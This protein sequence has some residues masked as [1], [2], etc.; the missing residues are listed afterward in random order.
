M[1]KHL[2]HFV[3]NFVKGM[4]LGNTMID[5]AEMRDYRRSA[6]EV[7]RQKNE[8][9]AGIHRDK[10]GIERGKAD[11]YIER[12]KALAAKDRAK[13]A[14]GSG[15]AN[16]SGPVQEWTQTWGQGV[17]QDQPNYGP[18]YVQ[19][20]STEGTTAPTGGYSSTDTEVGTD[21]TV[22]AARGGR[23][24]QRMARGGRSRQLAG[25]I[26]QGAARGIQQMN[27]PYNTPPFNPDP[28]Q[29]PT[30]SRGPSTPLPTSSGFPTS[31]APPTPGAGTTGP[32]SGYGTVAAPPPSYQPGAIQTNALP[33][34]T[35]Q[36]ADSG[37]YR[38]G[39]AVRRMA[40]GGPVRRFEGGGNTGGYDLTPEAVYGRP[41]GSTPPI[42]IIGPDG[43]PVTPEM[44]DRFLAEQDYL[45]RKGVPTQHAAANEPVGSPRSMG[46]DTTY[47]PPTEYGRRAQEAARGT[48]H[49]P[50]SQYGTQVGPSGGDVDPAGPRDWSPTPQREVTQGETGE[51][52]DVTKTMPPVTVTGTRPKAVD[53]SWKPIRDQTRTAAYDPRKDLFDPENIHAVDEQ[54]RTKSALAGATAYADKKFGTGNVQGQIQGQES[55]PA[56][57]DAARNRHELYTGKGAADPQMMAKVF[58]TVDPDNKMNMEQKMQA[59]INAVHDFHMKAGNK[60]AADQSA[61]EVAQYAN[62]LARHQAAQAIK[63]MQSGDHQGAITSLINGYNMLPDGHSASYENGNIVLKDRTG[64]PVASYVMDERA[65]KN[66][67]LGMATGQLGWD[68]IRMGGQRENLPSNPPGGGRPQIADT[69]GGPAGPPPDLGTT[70]PQGAPPGAAPPAGQPPPMPRG[71]QPWDERVPTAGGTPITPSA[72]QPSAA[73]AGPAQPPAAPPTATT[74]SVPAGPAP[75]TGPTPA[76]APTPSPQAPQPPA[77]ASAPPAP[78]PSQTVPPP[79]G[80]KAGATTATTQPAGQPNAA[81]VDT[82]KTPASKEPPKEPPKPPT[83]TEIN[84]RK[85][86]Y[87][88]KDPYAP[89]PG[90][91]R[92][93]AQ[94]PKEEGVILAGLADA[95]A[96]HNAMIQAMMLDAQKKGIMRTKEGSN[97]VNKVIATRQ[98][99]FEDYAKGVQ[100]RLAEVRKGQSEQDRY[101]REKVL[102]PRR[103][104]R[105]D[106]K[107]AETG[108]EQHRKELEANAGKSYRGTAD[109]PEGR[110]QEKV[111][112]DHGN[113]VLRYAKTPKDLAPLNRVARG[114]WDS[115]GNIPD[116][117]AYDVA[118]A[119]TSIL[120]PDKDGKPK[121]GANHQPGVNGTTYTVQGNTRRGFDMRILGKTYHI[122]PNTYSDIVAL[123]KQNGQDYTEKKEKYDKEMATKE[124]AKEGIKALVPRMLMPI[125]VGAASGG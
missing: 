112:Y 19:P 36:Q 60:T 42:T 25:S 104:T 122:S 14:G 123:H 37:T 17:P 51:F 2:Q 8:T 103:Y 85:A 66:I 40:R 77:T 87:W 75:G 57:G 120:R 3:D 68:V 64:K 65:M 100:A 79:A 117:E 31:L 83:E 96:K 72:A 86:D 52:P 15:G 90:V 28:A 20:E 110:A 81:A 62:T 39:G 98:K 118:V 24:P 105:A 10:M 89:E 80:T 71:R 30:M 116:N 11:A 4:T 63:Q 5:R 12:M 121:V 91:S 106:V 74:P 114:I 109:Q 22:G 97:Y 113:S 32:G 9:A 61:F 95:R 73:P 84:Q 108:W 26:M 76:P 70:T 88:K 27:R 33:D 45:A 35:P 50:V 38:R 56:P 34:L 7:A 41:G 78:A 44:R 1:S 99:E 54:G 16:L 69:Q 102:E 21:D 125:G 13:L 18:T 48:A 23:I 55:G 115:N 53:D 58:Q 67:A 107:E 93:T 82:S 49:V 94:E 43:K 47:R 59:A 119:A 111:K 124:R 92:T 101:E 29:A 46:V 6:L